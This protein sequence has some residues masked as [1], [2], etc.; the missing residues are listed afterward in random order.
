[1]KMDNGVTGSFS[2]IPWTHII[3]DSLIGPVM[4]APYFIQGRKGANVSS[5]ARQYA[6]ARLNLTRV[7]ARDD[8]FWRRS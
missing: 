6:T 3:G 1:M 5:K 8:S 7:N 4:A 2:P